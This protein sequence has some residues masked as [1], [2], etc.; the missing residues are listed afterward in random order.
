MI[1]VTVDLISAVHPSR[2]KLLGSI[3]I[4]NDGTGSE[5]NGNYDCT[6]PAKTVRVEG[7]PRKAVSIWNL[8][9][10][11]CKEAGYTK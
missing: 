7:Y 1:R 4:V 3:I 11:A 5:T 9:Y 8:I 2:S 6:F 10:R